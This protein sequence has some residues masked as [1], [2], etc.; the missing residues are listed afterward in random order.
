VRRVLDDGLDQPTTDTVAPLVRVN[1]QPT[2]FQH[3]KVRREGDGGRWE[4]DGLTELRVADDETIS[5]RDQDIVGGRSLG[6]EP[7]VHRWCWRG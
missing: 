2:E 6:E 4:G 5:L 7:R 1:G 3:V